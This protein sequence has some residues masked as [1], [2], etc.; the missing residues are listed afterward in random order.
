M[1]LRPRPTN[2]FFESLNET[3]KASIDTLGPV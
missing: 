2:C 1:M 3:I